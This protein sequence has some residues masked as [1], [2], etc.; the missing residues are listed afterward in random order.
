MVTLASAGKV[1]RFLIWKS[2]FDFSC[3]LPLTLAFFALPCFLYKLFNISIWVAYIGN[4]VVV[5]R[6]K[7]LAILC[8][9]NPLSILEPRDTSL[10]G[11]EHHKRRIRLLLGFVPAMLQLTLLEKGNVENA[12]CHDSTVQK[13]WL[14][15]T[16]SF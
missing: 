10:L 14:L 7:T 2:L 15:E 11:M 12:S 3:F 6:I 13:L 9:Y 1:N 5:G 8:A 16:V 4:L